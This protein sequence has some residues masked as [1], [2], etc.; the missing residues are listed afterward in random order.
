M[1][2]WH[3]LIGSKC[4]GSR[5]P[6]VQMDKGEGYDIAS[7]CATK[8]VYLNHQFVVESYYLRPYIINR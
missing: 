1:L 7:V 2:L 6:L 3:L 4:L 5:V 8:A